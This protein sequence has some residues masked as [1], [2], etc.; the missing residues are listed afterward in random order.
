MLAKQAH[1]T[2]LATLFGVYI[3]SGG[4]SRQQGHAGNTGTG[5][6]GG[7]GGEEKESNRGTD[8]QYA[9]YRCVGS[10]AWRCRGV[11]LNMHVGLP[12]NLPHS[13]VCITFIRKVNKG[14]ARRLSCNPAVGPLRTRLLVT[15]W[16]A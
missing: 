4:R 7:D 1:T 10:K 12:V 2:V 15:A 6:G 3:R 5:D 11:M 16:L 9:K 13:V 14:K 8:S